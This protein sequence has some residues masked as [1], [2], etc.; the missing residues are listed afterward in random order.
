MDLKTAQ[1]MFDGAEDYAGTEEGLSDHAIG[2]YRKAF[3]AALEIEGTTDSAGATDNTQN[4][5]AT[6][7]ADQMDYLRQRIDL[8]DQG[9]VISQLSLWSR[10]LRLL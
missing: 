10:Q 3:S 2:M 8:E 1:E 9:S 5:V 4:P 6:Q 7:I